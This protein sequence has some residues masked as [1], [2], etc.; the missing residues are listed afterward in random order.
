MNIRG[1]TGS[2]RPSSCTP[3]TC[4][5]PLGLMSFVLKTRTVGVTALLSSVSP[6]SERLN[7]RVV[8]GTPTQVTKGGAQ[9]TAGLKIPGA[10]L[11]A[12]VSSVPVYDRQ[13]RNPVSTSS[14]RGAWRGK[15]SPVP[16]DR[17]SH[18]SE[19]TKNATDLVRGLK[20]FHR[21]LMKL[22]GCTT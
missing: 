15:P 1:N 12:F 9:V 19:I 5:S 4:L 22:V 20:M 11:T 14:W 18:P 8:S 17:A 10:N 6:C 21:T 13:L 3:P 2:P 7:L 16:R